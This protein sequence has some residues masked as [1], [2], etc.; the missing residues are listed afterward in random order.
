MPREELH[1]IQTCHG[2]KQTK[3]CKIPEKKAQT[4]VYNICIFSVYS[5]AYNIRLTWLST[6][7]SIILLLWVYTWACCLDTAKLM[8]TFFPYSSAVHRVNNFDVSW[9]PSNDLCH[10]NTFFSRISQ[11]LVHTQDVPE[12][13]VIPPFVHVDTFQNLEKQQRCFSIWWTL[14]CEI[15]V[16]CWDDILVASPLAEEQL[17]HLWQLCE[18]LVYYERA[19]SPF[20]PGV[21]RSR[22]KL[23]ILNPLI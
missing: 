1:L 8:V 2:E 16:T 11:L 13:A 4:F 21:N 22:W 18:T 5:G 12:T 20:L 7:W 10:L 17:M 19:I 9:W 6:E 14:C 23:I 3:P 15:I